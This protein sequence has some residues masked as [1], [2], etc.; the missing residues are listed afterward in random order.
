MRALVA[1]GIQRIAH[2]H[3]IHIAQAIGFFLRI[4]AGPNAAAHQGMTEAAAFLIGP[5]HQLNRRFGDDVQV[6]DAAHHFKPGDHTQR[7]I[8]F[9]AGGLAVQMAA[10]QH[11]QAR[12]VAAFAAGEH[13]ADG[14]NAH[15]QAKGFAPATKTIP[16]GLVHIGQRQALDAALGRGADLRHRHQTIPKPL[17]INALICAA[18]VLLIPWLAFALPLAR[19]ARPVQ[20]SSGPWRAGPAGVASSRPPCA[21]YAPILIHACHQ[22][23]HHGP[24]A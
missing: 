12:G 17:A 5:I 1:N 23:K 6:M 11:R 9:A 19:G 4:D 7:T 21:S 20:G 14:I 3:A 13:I 15:R 2:T 8:E 10:E 16:P 24:C 22:E 18:H